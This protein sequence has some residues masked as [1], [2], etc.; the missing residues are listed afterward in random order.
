VKWLLEEGGATIA[1]RTR[2]GLTV[3][4]CAASK[5]R[6]NVVQWLL[7]KGGARIDEKDEEDNTA[8][9]FA[10]RGGS[11]ETVQWLLEHGASLQE[12][13]T[14]GESAIDLMPGDENK[15]ELLLLDLR[16]RE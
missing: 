13:N 7:E 5:G 15:K 11:L 12:K 10:A 1:E 2:R 4:L 6:L 3:L 16:P 14:Q 9:L 8:L